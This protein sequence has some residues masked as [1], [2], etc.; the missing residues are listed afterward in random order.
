MM[1][2]PQHQHTN[3]GYPS[4]GNITPKQMAAIALM[5]F[6]AASCKEQGSH[7][8]T[9]NQQES[10]SPSLEFK[11]DLIE[12]FEHKSIMRT[13][14]KPG[15]G[16]PYIPDVDF[17]P[18]DIPAPSYNVNPEKLSDD[19]TINQSLDDPKLLD[20]GDSW[21]E[22]TPQDLNENTQ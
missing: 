6:S 21:K 19:G 22:E 5:A 13:Q 4:L 3:P 1:I 16:T 8:K 20:M 18:V 10:S 7:V 9:N 17:N 14:G 11:I 2:N 15:P 12:G